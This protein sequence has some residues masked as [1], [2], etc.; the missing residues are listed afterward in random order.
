VI[1]LD[2]APLLP[3]EP[4]EALL[5]AFKASLRK[6]L[7]LGILCRLM[8]NK[9]TQG[10]PLP[11]GLTP[12]LPQDVERYA[13]KVRIRIRNVELGPTLE[14]AGDSIDRP[15]CIDVWLCAAAPAEKAHEFLPDAFVL[16]TSAGPL[17]IQDA[18]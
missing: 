6:E 2:Q 15:V 4:L 3:R 18:E 13:M 12:A 5:N 1:R 9:L 8:R 17:G 7:G 16:L 10:T 14:P 11:G